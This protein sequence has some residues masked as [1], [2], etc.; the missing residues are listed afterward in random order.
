[1]NPLKGEAERAGQCLRECCLSHARDVFDQKVTAGQKAGHGQFDGFDLAD[2]DLANLPDKSGD[3]IGHFV[4]RGR[5]AV[6]DK[7]DVAAG[8]SQAWN[9]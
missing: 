4:T 3:M 8:K 1:M 5:A 7:H 9:L 6:I 2:D